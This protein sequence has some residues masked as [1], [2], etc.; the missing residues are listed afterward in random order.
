MK[1]AKN[2]N[3]SL[4]I[5]HIKPLK[6]QTYAPH[7][8]PSLPAV[9]PVSLKKAMLRRQLFAANPLILELKRRA[10]NIFFLLLRVVHRK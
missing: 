4:K 3:L 2:D 1:W 10:F 7:F 9:K 5:P 8:R 6:I